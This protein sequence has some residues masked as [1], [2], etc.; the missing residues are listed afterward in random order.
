[1]AVRRWSLL[2]VI[3][4][5]IAT[6]CERAHRF[7]PPPP[8]DKPETTPVT[9]DEDKKQDHQLQTY[10]WIERPPRL[11]IPLEFVSEKS[12]DWNKLPGYWNEYPLETV[13]MRVR[14]Q[15][16]DPLEAAIIFAV[17]SN[18]EAIKIKVP[19]GLPESKDFIPA[20]NPPTYGKWLLGKKLFFDQSL[21]QLGKTVARSCAD[22]H[23]PA[24]GYTLDGPTPSSSYRNVPSLLNSVYNRHQFWDG[25]ATALEEVLLRQLSDEKLP[26][27]DPPSAN[28]PGYLHVFPGLVQRLR[29]KAGYLDLFQSVFGVDATADSVAKSLATYMRTLLSGDSVYDQAMAQGREKAD[30]PLEASL[31]SVLSDAALQRLPTTLKA[32]EAAQSIARGYR[33]FN[34]S[35]G[36]VRCHPA[37]LYTDE[38]FHNIGIGDRDEGR[39]AR[40]PYGLKDRRMIGAFKTPTLRNLQVTAPYMHDGKTAS[41]SDVLAYFRDGIRHRPADYIDPLLL[42]GERDEFDQPRAAGLAISDRELADLELFLRSLRGNDLPAV[43]TG[44]PAK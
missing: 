22:C 6:G 31:E 24:T 23:A 8:P 4:L 41:L 36:C 13:F 12:E 10:G 9:K 2:V 27:E 33:L 35:A 18:L 5:L 17:G 32:K 20:S 1:M 34:G 25:R 29:G 38:G 19:R 43:I 21:L 44:P 37:P 39:A 30:Q 16:P 14:P 15:S 40:L 3:P 28:S 7:P 42:S 11:D 26:I